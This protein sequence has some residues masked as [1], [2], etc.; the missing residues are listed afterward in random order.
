MIYENFRQH[1]VWLPQADLAINVFLWLVEARVQSWA[2]GTETL[3]A[4]PA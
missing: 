4:K 1:I 2:P 3:A